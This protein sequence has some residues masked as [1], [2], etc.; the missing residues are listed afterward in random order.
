MAIADNI[1]A[2]Q[3]DIKIVAGQYA[4]NFSEISLIAVSKKQPD[5]RIEEALD[6]GHRLF[7]ENRVQEAQT[8]WS[9][10]RQKYDDL[11]LHLIG[12]L[13]TNKADA[14]VQLFDMIE[15]LDRPKLAKALAKEMQ[16]QNRYL[17]CFIQVNI[18][19]EE[20]KS[21]CQPQDLES[22]LALSYSEGL[23]IDGLMCIPPVNGA[24]GV[25]FSF[26]KTLADLH[27]LKKL[28]MG[29]SADYKE[30]IA[31]G[32]HYIRVG[33]GIFGERTL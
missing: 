17:P 31:A 7:G 19:K 10:R 16:K 5:E 4:R 33:S 25:Y 9:E 26:L 12:P 14:A 18:G 20:Q 22:L 29:M 2:I 23:Q 3:N 27:G 13:Q 24:A 32:A 15:T 28:S 11:K 1:Q 6:V 8:R 30:A 21:G